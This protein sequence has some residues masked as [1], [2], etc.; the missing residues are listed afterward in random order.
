M[1]YFSEFESAVAQPRPKVLINAVP[2]RPQPAR[3][4]EPSGFRGSQA[5]NGQ[6]AQRN[7]ERYLAL[8]RAEA[9]TGDRI[10]A[11]N[12]FQHAEHYFRSRGETP[13]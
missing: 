10:Q 7:Y 8:A 13:N 3:T 1:K 9:L 4:N 11:E 6:N 2:R 5:R 12:Y